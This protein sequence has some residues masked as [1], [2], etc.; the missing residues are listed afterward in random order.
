MESFNIMTLW[1]AIPKLPMKE[2]TKNYEQSN[3]PQQKAQ[4]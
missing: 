1:K 3:L 4:K 2:G